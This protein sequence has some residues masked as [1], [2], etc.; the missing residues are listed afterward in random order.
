VS[1]NSSSGVAGRRLLIK[2]PYRHLLRRNWHRGRPASSIPQDLRGHDARGRRFGEH[3]S[4]RLLRS[5]IAKARTPSLRKLKR[6]PITAA[7]LCTHKW[8]FKSNMGD[9]PDNWISR[10]RRLCRWFPSCP[11]ERSRS[12]AD[13]FR[14]R[15]V[16]SGGMRI[17][18]GHKELLKYFIIN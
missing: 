4:N 7:W 2:R 9:Q 13:A 16:G 10:S 18:S 6:T 1:A 8:Q 17:K 14:V 15:G 3:D 11:L 12:A 5:P